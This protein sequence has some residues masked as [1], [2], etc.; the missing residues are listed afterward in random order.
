[1]TISGFGFSTTPGNNTVVFSNGVTGT[2]TAST[3]ILLT[4]TFTNK[5]TIVGNLTAVVTTNSLSSGAAVQ[6]ATVIPTITANT[7]A[8]AAGTTTLTIAG[9]GFD[10]TLTNNTVTF[11]N[12]AVGIITAATAT[13]L[14]VTFAALPNVA[15][16][17]NAVVTTKSYSS[18]SIQVATSIPAV[19]LNTAS[20]AANST[21]V[22]IEGSDF[23][24]VASRNTVV[25]NNGAVGTVTSAT[26]TEITVTFSIKPKTAGSLTVIVTTNGMVSGAAVQVATVTPVVTS[27][28]TSL[29]INATTVTISGSGFDPVAANNTV[30]MNNGAIGTVTSATVSL[31]TVTFS[32]KPIALGTLTA[33]VT[34]NSQTSGTATQIA[35]V[36]PAVTVATTSITAVDSTITITGAGFSTVAANNTVTFNNG[37]V[38]TVTTAT[39][40]SLLVTFSTKPQ[41]AGIL[42]AVVTTSGRSSGAAIQV[43]NVTPV[44][45]LST[46][47]LSILAATMTISG[48]GFSL[49]PGN[50]KVVFNNG[51]IGTVTASTATTLTITFSVKPKATGLLTALVTT[52]LLASPLAVQ[53]ATVI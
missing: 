32:T 44:V 16:P 25:F 20:L 11:D 37:A 6:I 3:A 4:V 5:P 41:T 1:M 10:T 22:V 2:V 47:N 17:L 7:T 43:A 15:G 33:I 12:G 45:T 27:S 50:N 35:T 52:N 38:G 23:D 13:S 29:A 46:A 21:T 48:F 51:A 39:A 26:Y 42:T 19:T 28:T 34:T 31:L 14:N 49:I 24:P 53:V 40:T 9:Y 8:L 18:T 30:V 36:A